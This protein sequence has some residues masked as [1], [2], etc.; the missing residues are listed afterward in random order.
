MSQRW[1]T[2]CKVDYSKE[3]TSAE[4]NTYFIARHTIVTFECV[5]GAGKN[6]V[7]SMEHIRV[8]DIFNKH[9][10]KWFCIKEKRQNGIQIM[11][12]G[13]T[14]YWQDRYQGLNT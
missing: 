2:K 9:Y 5:Y 6:K 10:N 14:L 4:T 13:N 1:F 7:Q 11:P 3:E 8:L 12:R